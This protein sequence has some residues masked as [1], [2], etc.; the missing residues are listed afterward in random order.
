[1]AL[2]PAQMYGTGIALWTGSSYIVTLSG[3]ELVQDALITRLNTA[4]LFYDQSYGIDIN[5][6]AGASTSQPV[7]NICQQISS[8][9]LLDSR[10][11]SAPAVGSLDDNG[12]L[13]INVQV[14][15]QP[16]GETFALIGQPLTSI[17][18]SQ[19]VFTAISN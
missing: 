16:G 5:S 3:V 13:T 4:Y 6:F 11:K 7:Q 17:L 2:T 18:A 10:V 19:L 15:L 1:M 9:L 12:N 14:T 8:Q